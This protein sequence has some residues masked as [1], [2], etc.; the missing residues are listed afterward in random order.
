VAAGVATYLL[1]LGSAQGL[2]RQYAAATSYFGAD[3]VVQQAGVTSVWSSALEPADVEALRLCRGVASLSRVGFGKTK[4]IGAPYFLVFGLD[5][6]EALVAQIPLLKG[7]RMLSGAGEILLGAHASTRL[8]Y[9]VGATLDVRGRSLRVSGVYATGLA[10]LDSGGIVDLP[11]AQQLFNLREAV[12]VAFLEVDDETEAPSIVRQIAT[13]SPRVDAVLAGGWASTFGHVTLIDGFTRFLAGLAVLLSA[14]GVAVVLQ[15][16]AVART[17]E[18]AVLRAIGWSRGRV[19]R[20][21]LLE[22]ILVTL[23]GFVLGALL[24]ELT[25]AVAH[26]G[27]LGYAAAFL[28]A[29]LSPRLL[30][31]ALVVSGAAGAIGSLAPLAWALRVAPARALRAA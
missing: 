27:R 25:L 13:A 6:D 29:H 14:T 26:S 28:P 8:G 9:S 2:L 30:L 10:A 1:L 3:V 11:T 20:L 12:N 5:P 19:A 7:Q 17:S 4:L 18:L 31:E 15:M 16:S 24:S 21:V 22:A 23:L